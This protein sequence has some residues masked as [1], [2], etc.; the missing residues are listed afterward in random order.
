[1]D[2][3]S[4][5]PLTDPELI[6][7]YL[8]IGEV[9]AA[10]CAKKPPPET[11]YHYTNSAGLKG[12][13]ESGAV[14]ATHVAFM[15]DATE[16]LHATQVLRDRVRGVRRDGQPP[17]VCRLLDDLDAN[18]SGTTVRNMFVHFVACFSEKANDLSQWR[19]YGGGEGGYAIGFSSS[20]LRD[21]AARSEALFCRVVY[22]ADEQ[23]ELFDT[24]LKWAMQEYPVRAQNVNPDKQDQHRAEWIY[25]LVS[26]G[27]QV[28]PMFKN[29]TFKDEAEWR[30]IRRM[31][32]LDQLQFLPK[33]SG[34]V[35]FVDLRMG[36][37][38]LLNRLPITAV[39]V[40]PGRY[41]DR[42]ALAAQ[43][44]LMKHNYSVGTAVRLE[45]SDVP[46][47]VA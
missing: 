23:S 19:A 15:N 45:V 20:G 32:S 11:L 9:F 2:A 35:P 30:L 46:Y 47:Q 28:A 21:A 25:K 31:T 12:I 42:S 40:G 29:H 7:L 36:V 8:K 10:Y 33:A 13:I 43:G 26:V 27:S 24:I 1:M 22:D 14:R 18:L 34:L 6:A 5:Q 44:L 16:Y 4:P 39:W 37:P 41:K 38:A 17:L 3:Q